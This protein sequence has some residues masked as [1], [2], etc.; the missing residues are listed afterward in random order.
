MHKKVVMVIG[1][2]SII[3]LSII[4]GL[5]YFQRN[6]INQVI[7]TKEKVQT[8]QEVLELRDG[9]KVYSL[10]QDNTKLKE[11]LIVDSNYLDD[12]V[13][14]STKVA[15]LK[16]GGT[17]I[18]KNGNVYITMCQ[19]MRDIDKS[20]NEDIYISDNYDSSVCSTN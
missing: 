14:H 19:A 8:Y 3:V 7:T 9:R 6:S 10:Y 13:K 20:S 17:V 18:Y 4:L 1:I 11:K 16:D 5:L 15:M 2:I 12:L